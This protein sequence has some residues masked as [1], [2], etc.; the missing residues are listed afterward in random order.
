MTINEASER[1]HIPVEVLK[2]YESWGLCDEVKKVMGV[3]QYDDQD[4]QRLSMI[5]T[6][7]DVGFDNSEVESYMRLL[8]EGDSTEKE[9]LDMLNKKRGATLDELHFKQ[10]QLD[11][12]D[13]LRYKIQKAHK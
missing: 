9:R 3:W 13:Y 6:L 10:K 7:H 12:V 2:E 1:Y 4:I 11:R 5:M 8:L